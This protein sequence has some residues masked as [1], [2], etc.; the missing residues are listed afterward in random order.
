M[1]DITP[2]VLD[3][4]EKKIMYIQDN[5]IFCE[6]WLIDCNSCALSNEFVTCLKH[7]SM[8]IVLESL[9]ETNPELFL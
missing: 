7:Q 5:F 6:D 4:I 8:H 1:T 3:C 9:K 2:F